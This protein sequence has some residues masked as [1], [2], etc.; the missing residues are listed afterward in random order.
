MGSIKQIIIDSFNGFSPADIPLFLFQLFVAGLLGFGVQWVFN[1]KL[2]NEQKLSH[3][4][5]AAIMVCV[6]VAIA[7]VYLPFSIIAAAIILLLGNS[8][9]KETLTANLGLATLLIAGAGCG[10]GSVVQTVLGVALVL[11]LVMIV[12]QEKSA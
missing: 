7:K 9:K 11:T 4:I 3:G 6:L 1:R 10:F 8:M 2:N 5:L 12:P